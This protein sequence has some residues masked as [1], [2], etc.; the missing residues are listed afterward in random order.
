VFNELYMCIP[1]DEGSNPFGIAA[2]EACIE[3]MS[4]HEPAVFGVDL[5]KSVDWTVIVGLDVEGRCCAFERFQKPWQETIDRVAEVCRG[6]HAL[7]DST[8]VGDPIVEIL[9]RAH[10]NAEGYNFSLKSKQQLMEG[11]AVD[12]QQQHVRFPEGP[13]AQE[14]RDFEYEYTRTGVRYTA[15]EGLHDDCVMALALATRHW[16]THPYPVTEEPPG[17]WSPAWWERRQK[18]S[19]W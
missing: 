11:L 5:A 2:I 10:T 16:V 18:K 13:I 15:P 6:K 9:Q 8:G 4:K 7:V 14:L 1:S 17:M 3:P 19:S 12:I